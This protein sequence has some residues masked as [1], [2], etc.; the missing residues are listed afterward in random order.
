MFGKA[1]R[2]TFSCNYWQS[3]L[4]AFSKARKVCSPEFAIK[5]IYNS[6]YPFSYCM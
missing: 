5:I 3:I 2:I 6:S 4:K 1:W